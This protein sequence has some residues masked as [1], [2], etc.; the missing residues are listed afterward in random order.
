MRNET[1]ADAESRFETDTIVQKKVCRMKQNLRR[2]CFKI[3]ALIFFKRT[4]SRGGPKSR[5]SR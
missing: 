2:L 4:V 3:L 5:V 1:V